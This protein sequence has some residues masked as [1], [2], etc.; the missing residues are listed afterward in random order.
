MAPEDLTIYPVP[1]TG[2]LTVETTAEVQSIS[3]YNLTGQFITEVHGERSLDL[4]TLPAG[5]YM[6]RIA[7]ESWIIYRNVELVKSC[8]VLMSQ[9]FHLISSMVITLIP[10][11]AASFWSR[12]LTC[13]N[14]V[15]VN[16]VFLSGKS[17]LLS[18]IP[19][20]T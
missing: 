16:S 2:R 6:I 3:L 18:A 20:E 15:T 4:S 5:T 13:V 10:F 19:R 7:G 14:A 11:K 12:S 8:T 1:T 9:R 17:K